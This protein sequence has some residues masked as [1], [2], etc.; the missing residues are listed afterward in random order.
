MITGATQGIGKATA[1]KLLEEGFSLIVTARDT[2]TLAKNAR[3]WRARFPEAEILEVGADLEVEAQ[4]DALVQKALSRF[5][6]VDL[7]VNNAGLFIPGDLMEEPAGHLEKTLQVNLLAPYRLCRQLVPRFKEQGRGHIINLC[8]VA[9]LRAYPSGGAYSIS[10]YALLGLTEN[11]R[12]ELM[13]WGIR[14]TAL[15]PGA[16]YTRSWEGAGIDPQRMMQA[17]DV[18]SMIVAAWRLSD[19]ANVDQIVMRP[20]K[21]DIDES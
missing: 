8:S 4:V 17:S 20:L 21:G 5:P 2:D 13:P 16:T 6:Q 7:L 11:L 10:K 15:C 12:L 14:V 18:A 19:Q 9:S 1:E 3:S